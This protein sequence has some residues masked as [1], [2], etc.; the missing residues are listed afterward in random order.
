MD[1]FIQSHEIQFKYIRG[2]GLCQPAFH[3]IQPSVR[4]LLIAQTSV[5]RTQDTSSSHLKAVTTCQ[6][7][8]YLVINER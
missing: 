5:V 1:I 4:Q 6:M 3:T 8:Y 2:N 7:A